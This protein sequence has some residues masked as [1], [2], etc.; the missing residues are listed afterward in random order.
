MIPRILRMWPRLPGALIVLVLPIGIYTDSTQSVGV[1]IGLHAGR[2]QVASVLRDC[3]GEP[4]HS[5]ASAFS[6]VSASAAVIL[7]SGDDVHFLIGARG[8]YWGSHAGFATSVYDDA[9]AGYIYGRS[10]DTEM[11]FTYL[12]PY[13]SLEGKAVGFGLGFMLGDAKSDFSPDSKSID[14]SGHLRVGSLKRG[15]FIVSVAEQEPIYSGSG[16][17]DLGIG[18]PL[19]AHGMGFTGVTGGF[20][21]QFGFSQQARFRLDR[22]LSLDLCVRLG[23]AGGA[24]EGAVA[25]GLLFHI[26]SA[27]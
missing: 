22:R 16:L 9:S 27:R 18:Y 20:Y 15:Y 26:G 1:N 4:L 11:T 23:N 8:G 25:G 14:F 12:N 24:F 7:P 5:E 2:G 10:P 3:S 17:F 19:G 6:D 13:F 21:D